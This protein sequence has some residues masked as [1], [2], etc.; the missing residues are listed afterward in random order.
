MLMQQIQNVS[1][2]LD[3]YLVPVSNDGTWQICM[4]VKWFCFCFAWML[5]SLLLGKCVLGGAAGTETADQ[6]GGGGKWEATIW[7][8]IQGH[9]SIQERLP[10]P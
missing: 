3:N 6:G 7:A 9:G 2:C 10:S 4:Y 5:T 1:T 8:Q